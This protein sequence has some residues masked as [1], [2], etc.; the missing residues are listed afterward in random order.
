MPQPPT[1]L[2]R[3]LPDAPPPDSP[4]RALV[5]QMLDGVALVRRR[6]APGEP[7]DFE[8]VT[9]NPAFEQVVDLAHLQGQPAAVLVSR[10]WLLMSYPS[11][12]IW[13]SSRARVVSA[14]LE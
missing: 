11:A 2:R 8:F 13:A 6:S 7:L 4:Y 9:A 12:T 10:D 3:S 14:V 5:E 1:S